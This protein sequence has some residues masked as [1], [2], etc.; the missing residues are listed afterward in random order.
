MPIPQTRQELIDQIEAAFSK[1]SVELSEVDAETARRICV[2]D[3]SVKDML[4]VRLWWTRSVLNWVEA[5][6]QGKVPTTPAKGYGWNET[7]RLNASIVRK[8]SKRT[9]KAIV[10]DLRRQYRRLLVTIDGLEDR[11]LLESGVYAWA[12]SY[13]IA[14]WLSINTARQYQ[15]ARTYIRR[16]RKQA[17]EN[18]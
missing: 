9:F 11:E 12:G 3:W 8:A 18:N 14:R 17:N 5:G 7:P 15:T 6:R 2:D 1:L 10:T 16:V 4:A 13:P